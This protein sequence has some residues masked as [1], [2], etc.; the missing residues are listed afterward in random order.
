MGA[1]GL[2]ADLDEV[3]Q[4][5]GLHDVVVGD[6]LPPAVD[7]RH[8][9]LPARVAPNGGVDRPRGGI[10]VPLDQGVVDLDRHV[11]TEG[12][13]EHGVG[14]LPLGHDHD[15]GGPH[16]QAGDDPLTLGGPG[17][18]H[19]DPHG[20][21]RPQYVGAVPAHGGVGGDAGRLVHHHNVLVLV[22]EPH[23]PHGR[24]HGTGGPGVG[25]VHL[26][27]GTGHQAL[28]LA[29]LP[30]VDPYPSACADLLRPGA[31]QA[32]HAGQG[33][34]QALPDQPLGHRQETQA[35]APAPG[36]PA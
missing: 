29:D 31:G 30:A 25:Q 27:G 16:V 18:G 26:Q 21:Q 35:H 15:P 33:R 9:P 12:A 4:G 14:T 23:A 6:R 13:L 17:G 1:T 34:V 20:G 28:G 8:A 7:D 19:A 2:Q 11:L 3:G 36:A 5:H 10:Q 24:G 22:E 32:G